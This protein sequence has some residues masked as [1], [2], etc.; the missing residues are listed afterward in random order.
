M[1]H[2]TRHLVLR[3]GA[4]I[5]LTLAVL[6]VAAVALSQTWPYDDFS[7]GPPGPI[8][9]DEHTPSGM[10]VIR[11]SGP[12]RWDQPF[13]N[14]GVDT[15]SDRWAEVYG[16]PVSAGF[17]DVVVQPDELAASFQ[18]PAIR[19]YADQN[20]CDVTEVYAILPNSVA[21]G[22]VYRLMIDTSYEPNPLRTIHSVIR[23]ERFL[24]LA[25]GVPIPAGS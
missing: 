22:A 15:F 19:F 21:P 2:P 10:P 23:T 5:T 16:P 4:Y 11:A 14:R 6:A 25:P 12:V 24:V 9:S 8:K 18:L 1:R 3:I 7:Y 20:L 13:C 17:A